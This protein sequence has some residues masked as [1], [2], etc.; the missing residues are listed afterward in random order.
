MS[1]VERGLLP[2][3]RYERMLFFSPESITVPTSTL[4]VVWSPGSSLQTFYFCFGLLHLDGRLLQEKLVGWLFLSKS[5]LRAAKHYWAML[6]GKVWGRYNSPDKWTSPCREHEWA[7]G[8]WVRSWTAVLA[9]STDRPR[10]CL[11]VIRVLA[12][13]ADALFQTW[14]KYKQCMFYC[15]SQRSRQCTTV[16]FKISLCKVPPNT[17]CHTT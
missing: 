10:R 17:S 13:S 5:V 15:Q 12:S 11:S 1:W 7:G 2:S 3:V 6:V 14:N 9:C 8:V 16:T 4:G